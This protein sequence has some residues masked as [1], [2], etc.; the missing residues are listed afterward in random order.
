MPSLSEPSAEE[1][2]LAREESDKLVKSHKR[3]S[4]VYGA[5]LLGLGA[6]VR[7]SYCSRVFTLFISYGS[8]VLTLSLNLTKALA[9]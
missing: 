8:Q 7:T 2:E 6:E 1:L 9:W 5:F 4:A 3:L